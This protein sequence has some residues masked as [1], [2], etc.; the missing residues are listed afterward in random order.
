MLRRWSK[1][2]LLTVGLD[3]LRWQAPDNSLQ[4]L[5]IKTAGK[6][7]LPDLLDL[8]TQLDVIAPQLQGQPVSV[9]I[10]QPLMRY[11]L[12]PWQKTMIREQDWLALARQRFIE[13]FG[14]VAQQ[15]QY[16]IIFQGYGRPVLAMATDAGLLALID[17]QARKSHWQLKGVLPELLAVADQH[18]RQIKANDWLLLCHSANYALLAER[19]KQRWQAIHVFTAGP[20][21]LANSV[22]SM[23]KQRQQ[24]YEALP[25]LTVWTDATDNLPPNLGGLDLK[26]LSNVRS[27]PVNNALLGNS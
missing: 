17:E 18:R 6:Q 7:L 10:S 14:S 27:L 15:W 21:S 11:Q 5:P 4:V 24:S 1:P 22:E 26:P 13:I 16:Q 19:Q 23:L 9:H 12:L 25:E 8:A 20:L 3:F 2:H